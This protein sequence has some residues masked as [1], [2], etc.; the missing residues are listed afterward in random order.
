MGTSFILGRLT[1]LMPDPA[2]FE[3]PERHIEDYFKEQDG[4]RNV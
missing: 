1:G 2:P 3:I 4:T